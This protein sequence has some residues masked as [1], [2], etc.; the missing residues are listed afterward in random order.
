MELERSE[1]RWGT[2][3]IR[4]AIRRSRKRETVAIAVDAHD[5]VV[6]T[7]PLK[8][9]VER[10]DQIV[11]TKSPWIAER[12]KRSSDLPSSPAPREFVSGETFWYLGR[13]YRLR[14]LSEA[15]VAPARLRLRQGWLEL[16]LP[17][18][19]PEQHRASYVRAALVDWYTAHAQAR[20]P[21][22][23]EKWAK[24]LGV[25]LAGVSIREQQKRWGSCDRSRH[26]RF[27]WRIVQAPMAL[28]EYVAAHEAVHLLHGDHSGAFWATLGRVMPD[29]DTRR[30]RLRRLGAVLTW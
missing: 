1:V 18:S 7:A 2:T 3:T 30:E 12:L 13:Q 9:P 14:L 26:L 15:A 28:I 25:K 16:P 17:A 22:V 24:R 23:A 4:Y 21:D 29:Y 5:G 6:L 10:L 11:K 8:A 20:L 27:N 19:L